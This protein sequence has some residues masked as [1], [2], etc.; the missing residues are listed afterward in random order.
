MF[1][2]MKY[3]VQSHTV[4]KG[5]VQNQTDSEDLPLSQTLVMATWF[6]K[7]ATDK[8]QF[9]PTIQLQE[10]LKNHSQ[11]FIGCPLYHPRL[12]SLT[13]VAVSSLQTEVWL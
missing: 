5:N 12:A 6:H 4:N 1:R 7:P 2:E 13:I 8:R 9:Y 11:S 3:F 10:D